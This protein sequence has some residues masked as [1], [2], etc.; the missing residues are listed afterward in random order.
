MKKEFMCSRL[1]LRHARVGSTVAYIYTLLAQPFY[2]DA[3]NLN[4]IFVNNFAV[5]IDRLQNKR[6]KKNIETNRKRSER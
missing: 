4:F 2:F 3:V 6:T 1:V 5:S